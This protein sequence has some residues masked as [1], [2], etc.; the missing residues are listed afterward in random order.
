MDIK[1]LQLVRCSPKTHGFKN[2]LSTKIIYLGLGCFPGLGGFV[3]LVLGD[4]V[5][6]RGSFSV[7][8]WNMYMAAK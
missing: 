5:D 2:I 6:L 3:D 8:R 1:G 4:L 7:Y